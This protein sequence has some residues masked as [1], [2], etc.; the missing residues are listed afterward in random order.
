[1]KSNTLI[2]ISGTTKG[3]GKSLA[4]KFNNHTILHLNRTEFMN[5]SIMIDLAKKNISL[6]E[7][8][9]IIKNHNKLVF[10][11]NAAT[12]KPLD[13]IKNLEDQDIENSIFTNYI[14]PTKIM[15]SIIQ[16]GKSYVLLNITSGAAFT[17]NTGLSMYSASKAAMHRFIDILKKEEEDNPKALFIDN[18]DPGR[19]QT[20][21][22]KYLINAKNF[23]SNIEDFEKPEN[24]A[25][26]IH[27][28]IGKYL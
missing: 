26:K 16:S 20:D 28:L 11:S 18:F 19:M 22:Q 12:I 24:I 7:F 14:N 15:L 25:N 1:M 17:S 23:K 10:I 13:M 27:S 21:M 9:N 3:L 5:D 2:I 6:V 4:E 8:K